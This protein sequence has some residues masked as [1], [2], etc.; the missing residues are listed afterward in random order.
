METKY[1]II[2]STEVLKKLLK[3]ETNIAS[4]NILLKELLLLIKIKDVYYP[5][6][7]LN[8]LDDYTVVVAVIKKSGLNKV[9]V[10]RTHEF[11][12]LQHLKEEEYLRKSFMSELERFGCF[13]IKESERYYPTTTEFFADYEI[14]KSKYTLK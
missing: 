2:E 5:V 6:I 3:G 1:F 8:Q 9:K 4:A 10:V 13:G 11:Y 7:I 14:I 12:C